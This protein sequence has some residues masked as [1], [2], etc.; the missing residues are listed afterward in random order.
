MKNYSIRLKDDQVKRLNEVATD[1]QRDI[2]FIIRAAIDSYLGTPPTENKPKPAKVESKPPKEGQ[3]TKTKKSPIKEPVMSS[4]EQR[5]IE[6]MNKRM[7]EL[8][9]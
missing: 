6:Y 8:S 9:K 5:R 3:Q 1:Q 2:S 4:A 7:K